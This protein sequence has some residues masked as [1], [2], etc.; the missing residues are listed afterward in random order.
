VTAQAVVWLLV[1]A[2]IA[3]WAQGQVKEDMKEAAS[4]QRTE[5]DF[6]PVEDSKLARLQQPVW[7]ELVYEDG[8]RHAIPA[9]ADVTDRGYWIDRVR[10]NRL[11]VGEMSGYVFVWLRDEPVC[12]L[13]PMRAYIKRLQIPPG[14]WIELHDVSVAFD[15]MRFM[16]RE[17]V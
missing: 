12:A 7:V 11:P 9:V 13:V 2:A 10:F 1:L 14:D 15:D 3:W 5:R 17:T 6:I 4:A 8:R 16:D